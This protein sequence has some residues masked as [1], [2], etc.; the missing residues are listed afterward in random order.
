MHLQYDGLPKEQHQWS[1]RPWLVTNWWIINKD[2]NKINILYLL[3]WVIIDAVAW[4]GRRISTVF[5]SNPQ[6]IGSS[7]VKEQQGWLLSSGGS[8]SV[9]TNSRRYEEK[10]STPQV[11]AQSGANPTD[12]VRRRPS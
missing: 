9:K 6:I 7:A 1:L 12:V 2:F 10:S 4:V 8:C 3:V 11:Q 5:R